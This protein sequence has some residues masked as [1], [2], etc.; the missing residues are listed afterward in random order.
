MT[1]VANRW[2]GTGVAPGTAVAAVWRADR[3]VPALAGPLDPG[4]VEAAYHAVAA[5]LTGLADRVRAQGRGSAAD[6]VATGALIATDPGLVAAA[7]TA[8]GSA[9]PVSAILDAVEGYARMFDGLADETLRERAADVRQVGRRVVEHLTG[10]GQPPASGRFVLVAGDVGPAD[11]LEQ[12]ARGLVAAET[13]RGGANSHAAIVARSVGLPLVVG[14]DAEVLDLPDGTPLL[15]DADAGAVVAAPPPDE[16]YRVEQAA[17]RRARRQAALAAERQRPHVTAD[18]YRFE[19]LC[20]VASDT[21]VR[22][23]RD[24]GAEGIGLLRTELSFLHSGQWPDG[25]EH[26]RV[27]RPILTEAA[28]W[29]VT[30]RLLDFAGD[31]VP[32]FL[33]PAAAGLPA[34]L[35]NPDALVAQ[36]RAI[37]D[38]GSEVTLRIMVPMVTEPGQLR[39]VRDAVQGIPV[40]AMVETVAAVDAIGELSAVADFFSIGTNDLTAEVLGLDRTDPRARPQLAADPRVLRLVARVVAGTDRPVSVCGDAGAHPTTLPLLLGAGVRRFSVACARLDEARY[41]LRRLDIATCA[42][43]TA[44]ALELPDVESVEALVRQRIQEALP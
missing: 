31:K 39:A 22:L 37:V 40:G 1:T 20:N 24:S 38:L 7:R 34:L 16:L 35:R 15:V 42:D 8:A 9:E 18:G 28:G 14:V 11:L 25:A 5:D 19:L 10:A 4:R 3:P 43:L 2:T 21:E 17:L 36:L 44:Q 13:V 23:G 41:R 12:L 26:R 27:L 6:I 32:P 33:D 30:V 29:P